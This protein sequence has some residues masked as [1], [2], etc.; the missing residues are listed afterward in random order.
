M[1]PQFG[2]GVLTQSPYM[3]PP[4]MPYSYQSFPNHLHGFD[5]QY[6]PFDY[7]VQEDGAEP[8]V[9][10]TNHHLDIDIR[11]TTSRRNSP[12]ST[13]NL[14]VSAASNCRVSLD[15]V[16]LLI[17]HDPSVATSVAAR[18]LSLLPSPTTKQKVEMYTTVTNKRKSTAST[19][20]EE[21]RRKKT[22]ASSK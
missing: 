11:P 19:G 7:D 8:T 12:L 17:Q 1:H 20:M 14:I 2:G 4:T 21:N 6:G 9:T 5:P 18:L 22:T 3:P 10:V 16:Y 13:E 15:C